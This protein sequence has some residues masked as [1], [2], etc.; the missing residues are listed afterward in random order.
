MIKTR[1]LISLL[2]ISNLAF[3]QTTYEFLRMDMSPRAAGLAGSFV[4]ANDDPDVIFY[5]PA[6]LAY[7]ENTPVSLTYVNHLLDINFAGLSCSKNFEG[8][9]RFGGAIKYVNYGSFTGADQD[10]NK[11]TDFSAGEIA[12]DVAYSNFLGEN[13]AYGGAVKFIYSSLAG[14]S[15]TAAGV[16][17]G[18]NYSIPQDKWN[19]GFAMLN[20]GG[21]LS[22][23]ASTKEKIPFEIVIGVSKKFEKVPV[24]LYFD[25]HRLND[26]NGGFKKRF[27]AFSFGGELNL[28]KALRVRVGYDNK[29]RK[30]LTIDNYAGLAGFNLGVGL[31]IKNYTFNYSFSSM[32]DVG[33]LHRI[34]LSTSFD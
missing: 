23:Y 26:D 1:L 21:Q 13:L 14:Y 29:K 16:D 11:L 20:M 5:N 31:T 9:G 22:S 33:A 3:A 27:N 6:G 10:G 24:K 19:I 4:S 34:G 32:G 15:S 30:D 17:V 7:I 2:F 8:I 18:L 28:S 12:F 25:I